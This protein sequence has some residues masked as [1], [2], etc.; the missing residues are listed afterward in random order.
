MLKLLLISDINSI[1]NIN[2]NINREKIL[3]R[4]YI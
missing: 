4:E 1:N 3:R 2:N